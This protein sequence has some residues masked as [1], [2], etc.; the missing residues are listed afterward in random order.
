M[1]FCT[2]TKINGERCGNKTT[3]RCS[4]HK[5]QTDCSVEGCDNGI[6]AKFQQ[7]LCW[8]HLSE[9]YET[10]ESLAKASKEEKES[11]AKDYSASAKKKR[12][13]TPV[14][15]EDANEFDLANEM[16]SEQIQIIERLEMELI[17]ATVLNE[18]L[19]KERCLDASEK[20]VLNRQLQESRE[21][22][23]SIENRFESQKKELETSQVTASRVIS[24]DQ[25]GLEETT[26]LIL[27]Q[28]SQTISKI[29]QQLKDSRKE[30]DDLR[31]DQ[32]IIAEKVWIDDPIKVKEAF[33]ES[34]TEMR[35]DETTNEYYARQLQAFESLRIKS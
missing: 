23:K 25:T 8:K 18:T 19:E 21:K 9:I 13:G 1:A 12:K 34:V 4:V 31:K 5:R 26:K 2:G 14:S 29:K 33:S 6:N 24:A 10:S 3:S 35:D 22:C 32:K 27:F 17:E 20:Q 28:Y 30:F 11:I 7:R 16:K 15:E